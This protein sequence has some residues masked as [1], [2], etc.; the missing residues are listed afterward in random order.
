MTLE[1]I[2]K[3]IPVSLFAVASE[4]LTDV[5]LE[6]RNADKMPSDLAKPILHHWQKDQLS[7]EAGLQL[8]LEA[9][10]AVDL[11]KTIVV[12]EGL[13]LAEIATM[14]REI[15]QLGKT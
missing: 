2:V 14:L 4:K 10:V 1:K 7:T 8:L 15:K 12:M 6:S 11:E 3:R 9:S 5:I 13:G